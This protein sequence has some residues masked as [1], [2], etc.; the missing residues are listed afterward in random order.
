ME[1][2]V[3]QYTDFTKAFFTVRMSYGVHGTSVNVIV[4]TPWTEVQTT[5]AQH[6]HVHI[7]YTE[8]YASRTIN[9]AS[10][11]RNASTPVDE[12]WALLFI[13]KSC[14]LSGT[15]WKYSVPNFVPI[16][17]KLIKIR[18][19][20]GLR[21]WVGRGFQFADFHEIRDWRTVQWFLTKEAKKYWE[22]H[23]QIRLCH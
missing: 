14:M 10:R 6:R 12:L 21:Y 19:K 16:G 5:G 18:T 11:S 1:H 2:P 20:F 7:C 9:V 23:V 22:V 13:R 17:K 8:F 3:T 4:F 15:A